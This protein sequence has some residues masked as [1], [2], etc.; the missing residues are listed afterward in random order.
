[1]E[2]GIIWIDVETTG[3]DP[4]EGHLLLEVA[5]LVTDLQL[6]IL[7][8]NGYQSPIFYDEGNTAI[9]KSIADPYVQGMH[10]KTGL[11]ERLQ[12]G[13]PLETV[14]EEAYSYITSFIPEPQTSRLGGNSV[15]LD[16][17]YINMFLP[18]TAAHIH[19]RNLDVSSVAGLG[20]W[21][22]GE[23]FEKKTTHAAMDDIRESIAEMQFLREKIMK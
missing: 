16:R 17:N 19:Y 18:K 23:R 9:A 2:Q 7:D 11:W 4:N 12:S 21:W 13:K 6:N 10:A 5:V 3:I 1:M 8:D 14:D 15:G 20:Q 22:Y